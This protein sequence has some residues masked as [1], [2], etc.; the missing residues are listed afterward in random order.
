MALLI[1]SKE[2]TEK[3]LIAKKLVT[4]NKATIELEIKRRKTLEIYEKIREQTTTRKITTL[5]SEI[6]EV[7]LLLH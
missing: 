5:S 6:S 4:D 2:T 1:T 7:Y 3:E